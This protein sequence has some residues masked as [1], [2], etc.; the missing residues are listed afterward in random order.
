MRYIELADY[1]SSPH[2]DCGISEEKELKMTV[3]CI[4]YIQKMGQTLEIT[5]R[6]QQLAMIIFHLYQKKHPYTEFD[7]YMVATL[8]VFIST[9]VESQVNKRYMDFI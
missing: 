4:I 3:E 7:R 9:K 1:K 5:K 8:A 6:V 2:A